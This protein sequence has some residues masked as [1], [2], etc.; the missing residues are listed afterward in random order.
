[1]LAVKRGREAPRAAA[2][3]SDDAAAAAERERHATAQWLEIRRFYSASPD[4]T[5]GLRERLEALIARFPGTQA[6][7]LASER[8]RG[9]PAAQTEREAE[10]GAEPDTAPPA[11]A[12]E[13]EEA[14]QR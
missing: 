1:M 14:G 7:A 13:G 3:A 9:L 6:A 12:G 10:T 5:E 4:D 8:L 2:G 11:A